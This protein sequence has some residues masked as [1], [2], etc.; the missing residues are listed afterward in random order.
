MNTHALQLLDVAVP[1]ERR[2]LVR[3][4]E[5]A[6]RGAA[7]HA[8]V[9]VAGRDGVD[10]REV[11]PLDRKALAEVDDGCAR[12][13]ASAGGVDR[14]AAGAGRGWEDRSR[15]RGGAACL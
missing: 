8:G 12:A 4:L 11:L 14:R 2:H 10:A 6:R 3:R 1:A 5:H 13:A 9:D 15:R 7:H